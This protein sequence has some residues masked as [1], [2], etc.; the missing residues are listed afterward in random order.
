MVS[1]RPVV[2]VLCAW[3]LAQAAPILHLADDGQ[4]AMSACGQCMPEGPVV[5]PSCDGA[6]DC[7]T[8][9]HHHHRSHHEWRRCSTCQSAL[10]RVALHQTAP[11]GLVETRLRGVLAAS[12]LGNP[13]DPIPAATSPRG[14]PSPVV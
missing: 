12:G 1:A 7:G 10:D 9:G 14:P 11:V 4:A 13:C 3:V 6:G 2:L 8:S 5:S